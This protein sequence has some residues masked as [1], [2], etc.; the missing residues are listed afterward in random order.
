MLVC[1]SS[2]LG[3][4]SGTTRERHANRDARARDPN[5]GNRLLKCALASRKGVRGVEG[6]NARDLSVLCSPFILSGSP[7]EC[8]LQ[9]CDACLITA[10][11][12]TLRA[13]LV[14]RNYFIII[15]KEKTKEIN[16]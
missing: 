7:N 13:P 2:L 15:H 9:T 1:G 3:G 12:L 10:W 4:Y 11:R 8:W 5:R 14:A 16:V 6:P